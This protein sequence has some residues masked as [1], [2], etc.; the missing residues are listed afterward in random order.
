MRSIF[1]KLAIATFVTLGF[2]SQEAQA[3]HIR[4]L[5]QHSASE[6]YKTN[7]MPT[8]LAEVLLG[9][10]TT[11][12]PPPTTTGPPKNG[13]VPQPQPSKNSTAPIQGPPSQR[14]EPPMNGTAPAPANAPVQ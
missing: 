2:I 1:A 14:P 13:T 9:G 12:T 4:G 7:M 6:G 8:R 5:V 11:V 10:P 3:A